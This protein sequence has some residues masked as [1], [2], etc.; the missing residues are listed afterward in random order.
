MYVD[1]TKNYR[2]AKIT[3]KCQ[4]HFFFMMIDLVDLK[5][6]AHPGIRSYSDSSDVVQDNTQNYT[7]LT[8][9]VDNHI[10]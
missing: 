7:K 9:K 6:A 4:Y 5:K 8:S 3:S 10:N 2:N 1:E